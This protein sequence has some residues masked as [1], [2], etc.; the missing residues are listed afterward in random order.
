MIPL[1]LTFQ[2]STTNNQ[3]NQ[4]SQPASLQTLLLTRVTGQKY[5]LILFQ[6]NNFRITKACIL[7]S[8]SV[9]AL[10]G[11][12][13]VW[14]IQGAVN[15]CGTLR[16]GVWSI[17]EFGNGVVSFRV[18]RWDNTTRAF[19]RVPMTGGDVCSS[20]GLNLGG[21]ADTILTL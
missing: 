14:G 8:D 10:Q 5:L 13:K 20:E 2:P 1:T 19:L 9:P 17:G 3:V 15:D 6:D 18:N 16:Y 11:I 12:N 4:L 7:Q 21:P